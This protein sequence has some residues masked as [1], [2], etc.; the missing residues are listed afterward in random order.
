M[1]VISCYLK[2][3]TDQVFKFYINDSFTLKRAPSSNK[4]RTFKL[5]N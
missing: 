5:E 4:L 3:Q 2:R 1:L